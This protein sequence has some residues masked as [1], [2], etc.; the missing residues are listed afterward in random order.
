MMEVFAFA[1][2]GIGDLVRVGFAVMDKGENSCPRVH[3]NLRHPARRLPS[4]STPLRSLDFSTGE[5]SLEK[6]NPRTS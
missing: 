5:S 1:S 4:G 2:P 6:K 3:G